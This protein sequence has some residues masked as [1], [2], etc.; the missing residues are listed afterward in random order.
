MT[1]RTLMIVSGGDAPGINTVLARMSV[2]AS[3]A[4]DEILGAVGGLPGVLQGDI[5][6]LSP[7]VIGPF[8]AM[9]GT[10]LPS[11]REPVLSRDSAHT[12][13]IDALAYH[14][15]DNVILFGGNG[16]LHHVLPLLAAW[17][18]P[19]IG[20]PVTIDN[21]VPG[22]ERTLGH[23]S[24][25]NYAIQ[26]VDGVRATA[27]ALPGRIFMLETLGGYTG[28]LALAVAYTAAANAV[29]IPEYDYD[30]EWLKKRLMHSIYAHGHALLV[31]S[32]GIEAHDS[33]R[34]DIPEWTGIRMRDIR[35]GHGQRGGTPTH[36]DRLLATQMAHTAH[37]ALR[38]GQRLGVVVVRDGQPV[39]HEG[40]LNGFPEPV[41]NR[42]QYDIVNGFNG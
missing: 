2:I 7:S 37:R 9:P 33:L 21:D 24:A 32:E 1:L 39:L 28:F 38:N 40:L 17:D 12:E 20:L 4:G 18:I 10:Y 14:H 11:S 26:A 25:C 31:I 27:R 30:D 15:I 6:P 13:M 29:L 8:E 35:L 5:V 3:E 16:T 34:T 36:I 42:E 41:P 23:D 22:T 19:C